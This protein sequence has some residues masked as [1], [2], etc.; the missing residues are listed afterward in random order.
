[1]GRAQATSKALADSARRDFRQA[2][3][4]A[5]L[6]RAD[7]GHAVGSSPSQVDRFER[8]VLKDVRLEQLCRL[9]VAVGLSPVVR[10]YPDGDAVRDAGQLRVLDRLRSRLP[11]TTRLRTEVPLSGVSDRR[12]WDAVFATDRCLDAFEIETRLADIQAVERRVLLKL[13]DDSEV[14]HVFLVVADTRANR[15][16]LATGRVALAGSFPLDTRAALAALGV[17]R[18]PGHNGLIVL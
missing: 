18:C 6:S 2:R 12:A 11:S 14:R 7:I 4:A 3:I 1:M 17:G 9:A 13:R 15:L 16:A 5:G 10:L 8:G